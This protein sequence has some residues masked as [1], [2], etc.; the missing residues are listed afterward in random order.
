MSRT[1]QLSAQLLIDA[2]ADIEARDT[3]GYTPLHRMASNNLPVGARALL[4]AGADPAAKTGPPYAGDTP[5]SIAKA[6]GARE[7]AALLL[8]YLGR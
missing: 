5:L 6:S 4:E 1:G 7:V 3:Y 2:G 8:T